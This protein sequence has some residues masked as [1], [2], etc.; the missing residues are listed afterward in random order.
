[1]KYEL[2]SHKR[3]DECGVFGIYAPGERVSKITY[4]GLH[5]LQHRGQESA[6]ITVSD[7]KHLST[8]KD[9]GLVTQVFN[10]RILESLKGFLSIGHVRYSTTGSTRLE[11][12]Q[13]IISSFKGGR[14]ALAHNGNLLNTVQLRK[15]LTSENYVFKTTSDT[16]LI[17]ALISKHL[18]HNSLEEAIARTMQTING[19]YSIVIATETQLAAS[20]D[21]YGIRPL[22]LGKTSTGY[23][24][25]SETCALDIVGASFVRDIE[26]GEIVIIN[27]DGMFS[28][29]GIAPKK[30]SMCMFEFIYFA[31]PDSQIYGKTLFQVRETLGRLL[32]LEAPVDADIVI[33]V[34]DSGTPSAVGYA[35][36]SGINFSEGLI[37]N[38]YVGRTF[39][40]PTQALRQ[41]GIRLKL[42]PL[43][44]IVSGKRVVLVDDS[45][46]R[47]N[48]SKQIVSLI[49]EA[50][51]RE[52]HARISSPP[53]RWPCFY[54]IDTANR[55]ELIASTAL[56][57]EIR[58]YIGADSLQYLSLESLLK[59]TNM[60]KEDFCLACLDGNY[61]IEI[62]KDL[63]PT[64]MALEDIEDT[65]EEI[66]KESFRL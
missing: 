43:K 21:P 56:T 30:R 34:P 18:E 16:E 41:L 3:R 55:A 37:K 39:I 23:V 13:P 25:A 47:G 36:E 22:S 40:E 8:Y 2:I 62:P 6:G 61:P 4:F 59:A 26:P 12:S 17:A 5:A 31:R 65:E 51:A 28:F 38:R 14:V 57:E 1:M 46:V 9:L 32:A 64:K 50:G 7:G 29:E 35:E 52:V 15:I 11:N 49:K 45:I 44:A 48:T 66:E 60:N 53:V 27:Q 54:G 33:P 24:I 20:R 19:A 42:N 58:K 63:K 10:E